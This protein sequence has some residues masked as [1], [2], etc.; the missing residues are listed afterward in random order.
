MLL[1]LLMLLLFTL[2]IEFMGI[3]FYNEEMDKAIAEDKPMT[4]I[5]L[6]WRNYMLQQ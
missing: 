5:N 4:S 3:I 2:F 1:S 6:E